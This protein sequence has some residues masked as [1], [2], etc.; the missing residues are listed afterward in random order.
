MTMT[1][2]PSNGGGSALL[3]AWPK[4]P[5]ILPIRAFHISNVTGFPV[6][7]PSVPVKLALSGKPGA[8]ATGRTVTVVVLP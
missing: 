8:P 4:A 6:A 3:E 7:I 5:A 1:T 2:I